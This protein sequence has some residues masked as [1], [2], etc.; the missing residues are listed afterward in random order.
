MVP[1]G[2]ELDACTSIAD[3]TGI[4]IPRDILVHVKPLNE[5]SA[6]GRISWAARRQT[7][8]TEDEA[9]SLIGSLGVKMSISYGEG[10]AAFFRLQEEAAKQLYDSS[11]FVW[12]PT[13][14]PNACVR[15]PPC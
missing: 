12:G 1:F 9:Y 15:D 10:R 7:T 11:I 3:I 5:V 8:R 6:S 4:P 13:P 14:L 2:V